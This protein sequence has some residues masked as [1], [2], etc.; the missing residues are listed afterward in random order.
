LFLDEFEKARPTEFASEM[1][2]NLLD[3]AR[4]FNHQLVITSNLDPEKLR[5]HW[6]RIDEIWG[7]SIMARLWDCHRVEL[8]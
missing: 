5:A 2:F 3:A 6:S 8:F 1:L 4:N 7:N